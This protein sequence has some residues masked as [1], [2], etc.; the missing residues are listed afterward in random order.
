M[1]CKQLSSLALWILRSCYALNGP[2]NKNHCV[3]HLV[4]KVAVMR[5]F[6]DLLEVIL[7]EFLRSMEVYSPKEWW[8][9][10]LFSKSDI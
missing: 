3:K 8:D 9:P 4:P 2:S 10:A 5:V 1:S 6:V 7:W